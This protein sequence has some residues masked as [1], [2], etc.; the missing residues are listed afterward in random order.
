MLS[1]VKSSVGVVIHSSVMKRCQVKAAVG[2]N[3]RN[4]G[5]RCLSDAPLTAF[6]LAFPRSNDLQ[7]REAFDVGMIASMRSTSDATLFIV[8]ASIP[9]IRFAGR[10][11]FR[12][13]INILSL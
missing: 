2:R 3:S 1:T 5:C 4:L 11:D 12:I 13:L 8:V 6:R 9:Q 7:F 10:N